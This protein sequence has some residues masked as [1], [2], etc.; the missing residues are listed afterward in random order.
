MLNKAVSFGVVMMC[1]YMKTKCSSF[2]QLCPPAALAVSQGMGWER[3]VPS[4][5]IRPGWF[6]N[7][8]L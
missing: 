1:Y 4:P 2:H 5:S 6:P 3:W 7:G 8:F